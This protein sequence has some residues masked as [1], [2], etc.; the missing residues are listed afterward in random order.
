MS[1]GFDARRRPSLWS[2]ISFSSY[3]R[4]RSISLPKPNNNYGSDRYEKSN[5]YRDNGWTS[6]TSDTVENIKESW[7]TGGQR[8]RYLKFGG[9]V[10]LI[11]FLLYLFTPNNAADEVKGLVKG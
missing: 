3:P 4:K 5:R 1:T 9:V 2:Y 8:S 10:A 11:V 6:P 7:M